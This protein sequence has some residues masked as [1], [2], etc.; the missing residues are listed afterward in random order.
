MLDLAKNDLSKTYQIYQHSTTNSSYLLMRNLL[1]SFSSRGFFVVF[2]FC[3]GRLF[4]ESFWVPHHLDVSLPFRAVFCSHVA[5][6]R[7]TIGELRIVPVLL[8]GTCHCNLRYLRFKRSK[9]SN[10][11]SIWYQSD[12]NLISIWYQSDINLSDVNLADLQ[13]V[14]TCF[15]PLTHGVKE[16]APVRPWHKLTQQFAHKNLWA[17]HRYH[18]RVRLRPLARPY[19]PQWPVA[20]ADDDCYCWLTAELHNRRSDGNGVLALEQLNNRSND[21]NMIQK[22][23]AT[24]RHTNRH[25][26]YHKSRP[27][28][29]KTGLYLAPARVNSTQYFFAATPHR[30]GLHKKV[31]I[32]FSVDCVFRCAA[33]SRNFRT[34]LYNIYIYIYIQYVYLRSKCFYDLGPR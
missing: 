1:N 27:L 2:S 17:Y 5:A 21:F 31:P 24:N 13:I 19:R 15:D 3:F 32:F 26:S 11:I 4:L 20:F 12:I 28:R 22:E 23:T 10:L 14:L 7:G 6:P 9:R 29:P 30:W 8:V 16:G 18:A 33:S 34:S 25:I